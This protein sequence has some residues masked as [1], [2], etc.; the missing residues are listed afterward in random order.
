MPHRLQRID[1]RRHHVAAALAVERHDQP[2]AAGIHLLGGIVAV[3]GG[4]LGGAG[5]VLADEILC[6]HGNFLGF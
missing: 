1:A 3:G 5:E 4:E 2:D 6:G